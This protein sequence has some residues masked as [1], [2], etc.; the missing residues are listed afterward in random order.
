LFIDPSRADRP[1]WGGGSDLEAVFPGV[2]GAG[3]G[4]AGGGGAPGATGGGGAAGA[5][6]GGG[7]AGTPEP[8]M[9]RDVTVS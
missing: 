1:S 3:G 7:A 5:A 2:A 4:G 6:G 8:E 9:S